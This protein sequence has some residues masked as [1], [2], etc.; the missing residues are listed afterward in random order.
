MITHR[1]IAWLVIVLVL[2]ASTAAFADVRPP[3]SV[4]LVGAPR[5]ARAGEDFAGELRIVSGV[6]ALL[7]DLEIGG[8]GWSAGRADPLPGASVVADQPVTIGFTAACQD[9][10]LPLVVTFRWNGQR[11]REVLDLSPRA[12]RLA[13]ERSPVTRAGDDAGALPPGARVV[14]PEPAPASRGPAE[15]RELA[16]AAGDGRRAIRVRGRFVYTRPDDVLIGVDGMTIHI[17][18]HDTGPDDHLADTVTGTDGRFDITFN[19]NDDYEDYPDLY[20]HFDCVNTEVEIEH[21][22]SGA[23]YAWETEVYENVASELN[24]GVLFSTDEDLEPALHLLTAV[25]RTWRW[26]YDYGYNPSYVEVEWP[27]GD[28][29][30]WY[31]NYSEEI[32]ISSERE[33]SDRAP[34]HE[35]GHHFLHNYAPTANPDYCN[36]I[37]DDHPGWPFECGHC[38]WCEEDAQIAWSEGFPN[39]LGYVI[40]KSYLARYG[41][42]AAD[43]TDA[44]DID[45]CSEDDTYHDPLVTEGYITAALIDIDDGDTGDDHPEYA[46]WQDRLHMDAE[47]ILSCVDDEVPST[48]MDFLLHFKDRNPYVV[49]PLWETAANCGFD[50]DEANPAAPSAIYSSSH[51]VSVASPDP[52]VDMTWVTPT[53]DASGVNTY[54]FHF[55][56][57]SP[58]LPN[59]VADA[60]DENSCTSAALSPGTYYFCIRSRDRAGNWSPSY[61]SWGPI[62]IREPEPSNLTE[63][64]R[65]GWD[66]T[67]VPSSVNTSTVGS[68]HVST[69]LPGDT[70]GTYWNVSGQNDGESATSAAISGRVYTDGTVLGGTNSLG[71]VN[72]HTT[73]YRNNSGPFFV[74]GGRHTLHYKFDALEAVPET[75]EAD[76]TMGHQYIWTPKHLTAGTVEDQPSMEH[77]TNGWE[78]IHDGSAMYYNCRGFRF[79]N[80]GWWN[81]AVVWAHDNA[82][83]Y[84]ARLYEASTGAQD[85]FATYL[86]Y[87][88]RGAGCLDALIVNANT[89]TD[90]A[91]DVGVIF[92]GTYND[93]GFD[94]VHQQNR[95]AIFDTSVTRTLGPDHWLELY[96]FIVAAENVGPVSVMVSTEPPTASVYVQFRGEDF[97]TGRLSLCD[98]QTVTGADGTAVL[99]FEIPDTG[100]NS[101]CFYRDPKN[102]D[103]DVDVTFEIRSTPP[104]LAP[105]WAAGWHAP[106]VPRPAADGTPAGVALPDTLHGNAN[107]TWHNLAL[108]NLSPAAAETARAY[109]WLDGQPHAG[110]MWP[111]FPGNAIARYNYTF[112][113]TIRGGR[114][115]LSLNLDA[116]N[117]IEEL[118]ETNNVYGEQYVWS[119]LGVN[120]GATV[121]RSA[122]PEMMGGWSY[123]TSGETRWY[124][125]DGLRLSG[126][127]GWWAAMAAMPGDTSNVD[128]RLHQTLAG[129]KQGFAANLASSNWAAGSSEYVL[130]NFNLVPRRSYDAGVIRISGA[131]GYTAECVRESFLG[132]YPSGDYGPY[133]MPAG[134]VLRLHEMRLA[135]GSYRFRLDNT[136]G[137]VNWGL[138][139]HPQDEPYLKKSLVVPDGAAWLAGAGQ[140]EEF[141]VQIVEEGYYLL[142]VWKAAAADLPLAGQYALRIED[143]LTPVVAGDLPARTRLAGIYPNPFNP[144]TTIA[145]ELAATTAVRV[146]IHDLTGACVRTLV[147]ETRP[148]GRH[149]VAWNGEDEGGRR[150]ASGAYVARLVAG[151]VSETRKLVLV[152]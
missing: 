33:W 28:E 66:H 35:Y 94:I 128:L 76:N 143:D 114:H 105:Y 92:Y 40:P 104:D 39:Y 41:I 123:V 106:L 86:A 124:D 43:A 72:A 67:L 98:A 84:D 150:V 91:F 126:L 12:A 144:R 6:A 139:L 75:D 97:T 32:H 93:L 64:A 118:D 117:R 48:A 96:E 111:L 24:L 16:G 141:V 27:D 132:S 115:T 99:Q 85:G 63:Y 125:C 81:V 90:D 113:Y 29:G 102:G 77:A 137:N 110:V 87:S 46:P 60:I 131:Q 136:Q 51:A 109:V 108:T 83:N 120:Q 37:C 36:S 127:T 103:T 42:E 101:L 23:I 47:E 59:D 112:P 100:Y 146:V 78:H 79:D 58:S 147:D 69:T 57:G 70:Y 14:R 149:E 148:A 74:R 1:G 10:D 4:E 2:A 135:P 52:T 22:T 56:A 95:G 129:A 25:T 18:D 71:T 44:Q 134:A 73:F 45:P 8:S 54:S 65:A 21:P 11:L 145:F 38:V 151:D 107:L 138:C 30:A 116:L 119:P 49:Q 68:T 26:C 122:P 89:V 7:T 82:Q 53:D 140:D 31:A 152:K 142:A 61:G 20:V 50:I 130:V 62:I 17:Y 9:A 80:S 133:I 88:S 19:F 15:V 3:V 55:H 34:S 5:M 121:A 13:T